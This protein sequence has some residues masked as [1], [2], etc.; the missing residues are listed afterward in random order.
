MRPVS[1][2]SAS[3]FDGEDEFSLTERSAEEP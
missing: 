3:Y 2:D 1:G